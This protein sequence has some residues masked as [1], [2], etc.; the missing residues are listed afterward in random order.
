MLSTGDKIFLK[1]GG[2]DKNSF[3]LNRNMDDQDDNSIDNFRLKTSDSYSHNTFI[4]TLCKKRGCFSI[5]SLNCQSL[6][7]KFD[8]LLTLIDEL[9]QHNI[10]I[11]VICLQETWLAE[12]AD[13]IPNFNFIMQEKHCSQHGGLAIYVNEL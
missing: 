13:M 9:K 2:L 11:G 3:I 5:L 8:S 1:F 10:E 12:D 6:N 7:A 4:E